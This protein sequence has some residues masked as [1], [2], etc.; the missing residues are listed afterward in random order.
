MAT[1]LDATGPN[2][3]QIEYWNQQAGPKWV[4]LQEMIDPQIRPLGERTMDRAGVTQGQR[5]LDVGCGC[6]DTSIELGR[7]VGSGGGVTG[8]D[9]SAVMLEQARRRAASAGLQHVEFEQADAQTHHFR[10]ASYDV[11]FSRFGVMFFAQPDAA[12]ANL[13]TALRPGGR[14]AFV[15]WQAVHENPWMLVPMMAAMQHLP[16]L[17]LP[18]PDAP[19]PFA[20][21]DAEKVR[22]ILSRAG[23]AD[24][25]FEPVREPLMVGSGRGLDET[26]DF[27]MQMGPTARVLRDADAS[28]RQTVAGAVREA[29][30]PY[31]GPN[32]VRMDSASWIVTAVRG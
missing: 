29:I 15:C 17:P 22:G 31:S 23:F 11:L 24:I 20:F 7:R 14:L 6:G 10:P 5:V 1:T 4:A 8:I 28:L 25:S 30:A 18:G 9:L 19:G 32:G 21:A 3:E 26:V 12:F 13:R 27:L 2:A 16:P